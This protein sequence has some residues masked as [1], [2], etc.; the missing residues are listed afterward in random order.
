MRRDASTNAAGARGAAPVT[1]EL[2]L[3]QLAGVTGSG[4][5]RDPEPGRAALGV[6][7]PRIW[8]SRA[9]SATF[10]QTP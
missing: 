4:R 2:P 8:R 5:R 1:T 3:P 9:N 10:V 7:S 6:G